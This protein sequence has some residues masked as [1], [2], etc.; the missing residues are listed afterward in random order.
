[1]DNRVYE[2]FANLCMNQINLINVMQLLFLYV[3]DLYF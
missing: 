2:L 3:F 1:M